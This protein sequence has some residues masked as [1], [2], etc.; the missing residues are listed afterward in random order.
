MPPTWLDVLQSLPLLPGLFQLHIFLCKQQ[1]KEINNS[2]VS[3]H[4]SGYSAYMEWSCTEPMNK[5]ADSHSVSPLCIIN[6]H[7]QGCH[8][9]HRF[10]LSR[11][12]SLLWEAGRATNA[13]YLW[14][15]HKF[16]WED[17][18]RRKRRC[19]SISV[20]PAGLD[21]SPPAARLCRSPFCFS[22]EIWTIDK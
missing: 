3:T 10:P 17:D 8:W 11:Q 20:L 22:A 16:L 7:H 6:F 14:H 4:F 12:P 9:D 21:W 5:E 13:W 18:V 1:Q 2:M 15:T 19:E